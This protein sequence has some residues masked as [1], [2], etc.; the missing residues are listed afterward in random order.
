ML[1]LDTGTATGGTDTDHGGTNAPATGSASVWA[2][3]GPLPSNLSMNLTLEGH[4]EPVEVIVWNEN[5]DKL[6]TSDSNGV[7][8]VWML[9]KV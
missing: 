9:Y 8:I 7:I 5:L 6:T 3:S 2:R 4:S 1:K